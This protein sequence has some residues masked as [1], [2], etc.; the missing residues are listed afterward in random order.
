MD[1]LFVLSHSCQSF[2]RYHKHQED[3]WLNQHSFGSYSKH[4]FFF[5]IFFL[6]KTVKKP[7]LGCLMILLHQVY[8]FGSLL[9]LFNES[10]DFFFFLFFFKT[11]IELIFFFNVPVKLQFPFHPPFICFVTVDSDGPAIKF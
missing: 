6:T 11:N 7:A 9:L 8:S 10:T 5:L 2:L 3:T 4:C 1:F